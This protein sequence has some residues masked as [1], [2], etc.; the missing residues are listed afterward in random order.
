MKSI[1]VL[2]FSKSRNWLILKKS[3]ALRISVSKKINM[4]AKEGV[5]F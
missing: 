3:R 5:M 2:E 4:F 1:S